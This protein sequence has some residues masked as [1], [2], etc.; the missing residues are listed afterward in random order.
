MGVRAA[1]KLT[2]SDTT[3]LDKSTDSQV[4]LLG[5]TDG[6]PVTITSIATTGGGSATDEVTTISVTE[7]PDSGTYQLAL[8]L[9]GEGYVNTAAATAFGYHDR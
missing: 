3:D 2:A 5:P 8:D 7:D 9:D 6:T 4:T 1:K